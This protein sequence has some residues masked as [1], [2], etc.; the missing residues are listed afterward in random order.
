M[1]FLTT[2]VLDTSLVPCLLVT[3]H[4]GVTL[5]STCIYRLRVNPGAYVQPLAWIAG[6]LMNEPD[7]DDQIASS[8]WIK[9]PGACLGCRELRVS[10]LYHGSPATVRICFIIDG[11]IRA[12]FP[13]RRY[14][15]NAAGS[16]DSD[17]TRNGVAVVQSIQYLVHLFPPDVRHISVS[18][19]DSR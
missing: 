3:Q 14:T 19:L 7:I 11:T 15:P 6:S 4:S 18:E 16:Y 10:R 1:Q 12:W 2:C 9:F 13:P 8:F 5:N 17:Q